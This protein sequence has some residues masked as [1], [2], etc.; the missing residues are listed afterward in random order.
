MTPQTFRYAVCG[1]SNVVL[2]F[3]TFTVI[4]HLVIAKTVVRIWFLAIESYNIAL[5]CSS[6]LSFFLGFWLNKY[7]VFEE[8]NLR[9]R[10]QLFRYFLSYISNLFLNYILLKIFV[11]Y[12]GLFPVPAQMIVTAIIIFLSYLTQR[13]YTFKVKEV[14][15]TSTAEA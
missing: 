4:Y 1:S 12:L 13:Y 8:S 9:G 14:S 6:L 3:I 2:S 5:I 15:D 11:K 10:V 7:I